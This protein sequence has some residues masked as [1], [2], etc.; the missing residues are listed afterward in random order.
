MIPPRRAAEPTRSSATPA[1]VAA[2]CIVIALLA[3][4]VLVTD[5]LIPR[6]DWS[7]AAL[8]KRQALLVWVYGGTIVLAQVVAGLALLA[9]W[10]ASRK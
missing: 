9:W 4:L 1:Q 3:A 7:A 2:T 5:P 8:A 10:K 6:T